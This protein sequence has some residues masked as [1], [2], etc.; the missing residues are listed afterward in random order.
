MERPVHRKFFGIR[1]AVLD[2]YRRQ[3]S[4]VSNFHIHACITNHPDI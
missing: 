4:K 1:F 2:Q 3:S